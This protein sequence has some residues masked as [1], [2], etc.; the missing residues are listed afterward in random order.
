MIIVIL[1]VSVSLAACFYYRFACFTCLVILRCRAP[2]C[3]ETTLMLSILCCYRF[4]L[5][6]FACCF[7]LTATTNVCWYHI[8]L[9]LTLRVIIFAVLPVIKSPL[10]ISF[11]IKIWS[12][13]SF[14]IENFLVTK[15]KNCWSNINEKE[16]ETII[17]RKIV[18]K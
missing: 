11:A 5:L 13:R 6:T 18:G 8:F 2:W 14:L 10:D 3:R 9:L 16:N 12:S 4:P 7:L 1:V 15:W 17:M